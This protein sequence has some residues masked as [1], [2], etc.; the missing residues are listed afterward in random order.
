MLRAYWAA[1][2]G[3]VAAALVVGGLNVAS[4]FERGWWL[5]SY[6]LGCRRLTS[7]L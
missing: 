3:F 2:A 7:L 6:L 5:A 4:P 1:G